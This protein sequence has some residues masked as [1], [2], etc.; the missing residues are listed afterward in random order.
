MRSR[1]WGVVARS[2]LLEPIRA[3]EEQART[4]LGEL[5]SS[6]EAPARA[7]I[8]AAVPLFEHGKRQGGHR[9]HRGELSPSTEAPLVRCRGELLRLEKTRSG[10]TGGTSAP[11]LNSADS[12]KSPDLHPF[13]CTQP[14]LCPMYPMGRA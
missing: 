11:F 1:S 8:P 2:G 9:P 13:P 5:F 7:P 3:T 14:T 12:I 10:R 6:T 4:G